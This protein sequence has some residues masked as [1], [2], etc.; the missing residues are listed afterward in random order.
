MSTADTL[1]L[2]DGTYNV[3]RAFHARGVPE[4]RSRDGT[5]TKATYIFTRMLLSILEGKRPEYLGVA[6]DLEGPTLRHEEYDRYV[7]AHP[8]VEV[9][10]IGYKGTRDETPEDLLAQVPWCRRVCEGFGVPLLDSSGYEAD[11]IIGTLAVQ[12][13]ERGLAVVIVTAD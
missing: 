12:A 1:Y 2:V 13:R 10:M 6:F 11:D 5:P 4:M 9:E 3:F 8:G 7:K